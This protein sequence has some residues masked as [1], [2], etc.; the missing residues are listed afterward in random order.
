MKKKSAFLKSF[1]VKIESI[2][3]SEIETVEF[4]ESD[5][6]TIDCGEIPNFGQSSTVMV[7]GTSQSKSL[8]VTRTRKC[9]HRSRVTYS[10]SRSI[11]IW[12]NWISESKPKIRFMILCILIFNRDILEK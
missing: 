2:D 11:K 9:C 6:E 10:V 5:S 4:H 1:L 8:I 7:P 3:D 12:L